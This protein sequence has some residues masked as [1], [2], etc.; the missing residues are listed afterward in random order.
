MHQIKALKRQGEGQP[1]IKVEDSLG[2]S[3]TKK[4]GKVG[5]SDAIRIE[6]GGG[7]R[8]DSKHNESSRQDST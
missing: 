2:E 4:G 5:P 6:T 1:E 3:M 8:V 7:L